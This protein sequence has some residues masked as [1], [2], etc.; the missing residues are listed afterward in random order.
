MENKTERERESSSHS[1]RAIG[2]LDC[3]VA[4]GGGDGAIAFYLTLS[5]CPTVCMYMCRTTRNRWFNSTAETY[6]QYS[7]TVLV[8]HKYLWEDD[9]GTGDI[10]ELEA[11][12]MRHNDG[13][14]KRWAVCASFMLWLYD[15]NST[16]TLRG[17]C[18]SVPRGANIYSNLTHKAHITFLC[19]VCHT[20]CIC[21]ECVNAR[22][23][24][25]RLGAGGI[26]V[27]DWVEATG[28]MLCNDVG[29][30]R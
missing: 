10:N 29:R 30:R 7:N 18:V 21:A 2:G 23:Q 3:D 4:L 11:K 15:F 20:R 25:I 26:Y 27:C 16:F 14:K 1:V 8:W 22:L 17:L 19:E 5:Q 6:M 13:A 28:K 9:V 12:K 24:I